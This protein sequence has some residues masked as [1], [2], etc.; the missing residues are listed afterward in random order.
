M[1]LWGKTLPI[2]RLNWSASPIIGETVSVAGKGLAAPGFL[3]QMNGQV[4]FFT[5]IHVV[6]GIKLIF[7]CLALML[8]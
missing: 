4:Y 7:A 2:T 6:Q 5:N 1:M 3:G 8:R